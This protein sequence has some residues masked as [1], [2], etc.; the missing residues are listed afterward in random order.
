MESLTTILNDERFKEI[1][2][3]ILEFSKY[4][5]NTFETWLEIKKIFPEGDDLGVFEAIFERLMGDWWDG[6]IKLPKKPS[7]KQ[8]LKDYV[9]YKV[10]YYTPNPEYYTKQIALFE[11]I[12]DRAMEVFVG[13]ASFMNL[14]VLLNNK[15]LGSVNLSLIKFYILGLTFE[16]PQHNRHLVKYIWPPTPTPQQKMRA[17]VLKQ[18]AENPN[19]KVLDLH[20][21]TEDF[22]NIKNSLNEN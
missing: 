6:C 16:Y 18:H 17:A 15:Y 14:T 19:A 3:E 1:Q 5:I 12:K 2:L 13:R 4:E 22:E 8:A 21:F 11:Y 7:Q 20:E 10:K 9:A